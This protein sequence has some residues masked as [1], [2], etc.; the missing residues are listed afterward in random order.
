MSTWVA[1]GGIFPVPLDPRV[2]LDVDM[3]S[4]RSL[5][6]WS[7][8]QVH[9]PTRSMTLHFLKSSPPCAA[10][11]AGPNAPAPALFQRRGLYGCGTDRA[12]NQSNRQPDRST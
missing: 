9:F 11:A 6:Q 8:L 3:S 10:P 12:P 1:S 7:S 2:E 4:E 5:W